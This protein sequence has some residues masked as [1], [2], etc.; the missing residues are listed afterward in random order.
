[1]ACSSTSSW[2]PITAGCACW[3]TL[4]MAS[5]RSSQ[6]LPG[7][8]SAGVRT[9]KDITFN[10]A[11]DAAQVAAGSAKARSA[12]SADVRKR[13][14]IVESLHSMKAVS[15]R[16]PWKARAAVCRDGRL[17]GPGG[18]RAAARL[19]PLGDQGSYIIP[20]SSRL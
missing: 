18:R 16:M 9:L 20:F 2:V 8:V 15:W 7:S 12:Q 4:T 14:N 10:G 5:R 1:M 19:M 17:Q 6:R 11:G 13:D 3:I